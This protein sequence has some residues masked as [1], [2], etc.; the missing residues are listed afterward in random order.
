M[1]SVLS[2]LSELTT[3]LA[4]VGLCRKE[5]YELV[6]VHMYMYRIVYYVCILPVFLLYQKLFICRVKV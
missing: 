1:T 6:Q 2:L 3:V 4:D 5:D